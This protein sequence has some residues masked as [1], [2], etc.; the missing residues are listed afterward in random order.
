[1]FFWTAQQTVL[2]SVHVSAILT[3]PSPFLLLRPLVRENTPLSR[4]HL[5]VCINSVRRSTCVLPDFL[6]NRCPVRSSVEALGQA[7]LSVPTISADQP[8]ALSP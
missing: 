7:P 2:R 1:M 6:L 3:C 4:L 5:S 8:W